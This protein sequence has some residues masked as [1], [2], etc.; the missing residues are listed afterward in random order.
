[1]CSQTKYACKD[2]MCPIVKVAADIKEV[3][4]NFV[5]QS[6]GRK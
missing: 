4:A 3:R 5:Q 6:K 1:M 2:Y